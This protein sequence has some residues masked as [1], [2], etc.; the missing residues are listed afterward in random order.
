MENPEPLPF[1]RVGFVVRVG[2]K[3]QTVGHGDALGGFEAARVFSSVGA[4]RRARWFR[5]AKGSAE[6][7][8]PEVIR[9]VIQAQEV[10]DGSTW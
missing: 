8:A 3:Y 4:A 6:Y 10:V 1:P 9:I 2:T 7:P 5:T